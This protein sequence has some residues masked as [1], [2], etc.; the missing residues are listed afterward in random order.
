MIIMY[1][2]PKDIEG[3]E[4]HYFNIHVPLGSKIPHI[5]KESVHRVVHSQNTG[6]KLYLITELEFEDLNTIHEALASP[7]AKAAEEDGKNLMK[8]LH[9]PPIISIVD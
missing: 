2:E 4:N 9:N 8:Y 3:F 7:E 5:K 1:E 6:L